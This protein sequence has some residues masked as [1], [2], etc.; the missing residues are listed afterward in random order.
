MTEKFTFFWSGPFSQW[1]K[2]P[3]EVDH[4]I[5]NCAEQY[6]MYYKAI[7]HDDRETSQK[8]LMASNP[9]VQKN[10]GRTVVGFDYHL[11]SNNCELIVKDGNMA[12]F[13]QNSLL[14]QT[15]KA[16]AGTTLVEASPCDKIWGI[17]LKEDDPRAL[18]RETWQGQNKLGKVLTEVRIELFGG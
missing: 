14:G 15:L 7:L 6:M 3:F 1:H 4:I 16:T 2:A 11:W 9:R 5:F 18:S 17:G 8:I 12:K 10:L 13:T